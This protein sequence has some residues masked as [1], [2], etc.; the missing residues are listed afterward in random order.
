MKKYSDFHLNVISTHLFRL[1]VVMSLPILLTFNGCLG[2]SEFGPVSVCSFDTSQAVNV[3]KVFTPSGKMGDYDDFEINHQS[4]EMPFSGS[5]CIK[6]AYQPKGKLGWT[7]LVW[8]CPPDNWAKNGLAAN[9]TG[10]TYLSFWARGKL[11]KEKVEFQVGGIKGAY[12]DTNVNPSSTGAIGLDSI[13]KRYTIDLRGK[14]LS[15]ISGGFTWVITKQLNPSGATFFLDSIEFRKG[16]IPAVDTLPAVNVFSKFTPSGWM[17]DLTDIVFDADSKDKPHSGDFCMKISYSA[18]GS[19]GWAGIY[20][21]YPE[22]NWGDNP[23][24][25]DLRAY[26]KLIFWVRGKKGGEKAEFFVGGITGIHP[27]SAKKKS[28]GLVTLATEWKKYEINL[29]DRDLSHVIGG[30]GWASAKDD[31]RSGAVIYL[32]DIEFAK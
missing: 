20:W 12:P 8:Q 11:G 27:D 19:Q 2:D 28:T 7:G 18:L 21:Q 25:L 4:R 3:I 23:I 1:S 29:Q 26:T 9:L 5:D 14:D 24:S 31:N 32:D 10:Y 30:F 6:I 22:K 15:H 16:E 17:G 13:W